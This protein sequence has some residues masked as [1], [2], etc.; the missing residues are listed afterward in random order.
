MLTGDLGTSVFSNRPVADLILQRMEP[1]IALTLLALALA[2]LIAV[3]LGVVA[4]WRSG[5]IVDRLAMGLAVL[6]FS[7]PVFVLSYLLILFFSVQLKIFPVQGYRPLADGLEPFLRHLA[8]P[9][10]ALGI[11]YAALIARMTRASM[12]E[13]L[14][15][16][17]VRTARAKGLSTVAVLV[18]HALKN[19]AVP[20]V[21][22][23]GIGFALL[24]SGV[25]VTET[26]FNI[27]G[28]GRLTVDAILR[29]D[30]PVIQ[31][32]ILVFSGV[33]V[34]V[35]L[36]VDLSYALFDPRIRY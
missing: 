13:V 4:A 23:I 9:A 28:V 32:V 19:A 36:L 12:L 6:G 18:G 21:T 8:L 22:V 31:G 30:Y 3:P 2:V 34:L 26:V 14:N 5:G 1:T 24:I 11:V 16:D 15:Q 33:Y 10:F 35:N 29:R 7:L 17:Y 20:I 25:V 27:P